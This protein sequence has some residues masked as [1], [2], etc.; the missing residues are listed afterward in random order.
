[1][2]MQTLTIIKR[3]VELDFFRLWDRAEILHVDM[4]QSPPLVLRPPKHRV[5]RMTGVTGPI[6]RNAVVLE[7]RSGQVAPVIDIQTSAVLFHR[8]AGKAKLSRFGPLHVL[9]HTGPDRD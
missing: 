4:R 8:V 9:R 5:V 2:T 6:A 1:M 7:M 3:D